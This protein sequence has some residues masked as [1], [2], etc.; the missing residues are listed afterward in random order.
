M[1]LISAAPAFGLTRRSA[2][3]AAGLG[4]ATIAGMPGQ[5]DA[6]EGTATEKTNVQVVG[7]FCAAWSSHDIDRIMSF[8]GENC[9]YRM[10]ETQEAIK[11]RQAVMDRIKSFL[12]AVQSFEVIETFAKGPLVFNERHD[13]FTG[14]QLKMWHGVGVFFLKG[15]KIAEWSDYTI[16]T[17]QG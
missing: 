17:D 1:K 8:F 10:L 16:S 15:G 14:G 3:T 11:G 4:L 12:N 2:F 9:A 6:A 7:D 5:A 13:H